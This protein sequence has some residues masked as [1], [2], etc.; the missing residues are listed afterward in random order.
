MIVLR[1]KEFSETEPDIW[2]GYLEKINPE[3]DLSEQSIS[4]EA[5]LLSCFRRD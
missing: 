5:N 4:P 2:R 3:I 1:Q